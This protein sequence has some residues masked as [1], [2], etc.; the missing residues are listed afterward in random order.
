MCRQDFGTKKHIN[1]YY[2]KYHRIILYEQLQFQNFKEFDVEQKSYFQFS[3]AMWWKTKTCTVTKYICHRSGKKSLKSV[4]KIIPKQ[5]KLSNICPTFLTLKKFNSSGLYSVLYQ[6]TH[7]GHE[8]D[9]RDLPHR[10]INANEKLVIANKLSLGVLLNVLVGQ[11]A[12][13][14]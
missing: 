6:K 2:Q 1:E 12:S 8:C 4:T 14:Q 9:K 5:K 3:K 11:Y 13:T 10:S 7:L